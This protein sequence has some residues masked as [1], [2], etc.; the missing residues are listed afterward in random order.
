MLKKK[1]TKLEDRKVE[2]ETLS[3]EGHGDSARPC[4][5]LTPRMASRLRGNDMF[6][7]AVT[8]QVNPRRRVSSPLF[9]TS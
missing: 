7:S 5:N 4:E 2:L 8:K 9:G 6:F 3:K 1:L